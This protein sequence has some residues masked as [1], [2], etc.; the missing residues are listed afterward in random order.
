[1]LLFKTVCDF[2]KSVTYDRCANGVLTS[3]EKEVFAETCL[4][5]TELVAIIVSLK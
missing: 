3:Y 4:G 2:G 1:M 5:V